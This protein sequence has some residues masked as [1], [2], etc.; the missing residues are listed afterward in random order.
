MQ[1]VTKYINA[2]YKMMKARNMFKRIEQ[3]QKSTSIKEELDQIDQIITEINLKA[4]KKIRKIKDNG[5]I[6]TIPKLKLKLIQWNRRIRQLPKNKQGQETEIK[7]TIKEK[8]SAIKQFRQYNQQSYKIRH[9]ER[10]EK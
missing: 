3:I 10:E 4:E 2:K 6:T 5:C 9:E 7:E 1:S 8:K